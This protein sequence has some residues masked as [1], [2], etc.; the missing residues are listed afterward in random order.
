MFHIFAANT[1]FSAYSQ[2]DFFGKLI[3]AALFLLSILSWAVLVYKVR[4]T[5]SIKK[6]MHIFLKS[7]SSNKERLLQ[8]Q[9]KE[10]HPFANIFRCLQQ[11]TLEV[12]S[13]NHHFA[14]DKS[15]IYLSRADLELIESSVLTTIS[16]ENK[17]LDKNLFLLSITMSLAPFLGLLGTVWG[18]LVTFSELQGGA[19]M[20]SS[21]AMLGGLSTALATTV[22]GL[23]IAIPALV[24]HNFLKTSV[25]HLG[26]DM[27]DFLYEALAVIELQY[28]K[29][30][31]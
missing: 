5:R 16:S 28:R 6:S 27:E 7:V 8:L 12:L 20:G 3:F 29:I 18:I 25:H 9:I 2:A 4:E 31:E 10:E 1:F 17:R 19:K 15:H 26:S 14:E 11:K 21:T 30:E 13:K 24:A 23:I 22:I